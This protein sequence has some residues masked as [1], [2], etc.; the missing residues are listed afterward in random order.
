LKSTAESPAGY[1]M[2][3]AVLKTKVCKWDRKL[4][5]M[6]VNYDRGIDIM[7]DTIEVAIQFGFIDNSVQGSFKL[8]DPDTGELICD[9][10]G[11]EIKIRG[12]KNI[13]PYFEENPIMWRKLYDKVY[14]K[15]SQKQ[16]P[17]IISFER[18][19]NIDLNEKFN[20]DIEQE[21]RDE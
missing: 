15:L 3:A 8:I 1:I 2:E 17:S 21:N 18:M 16:D 10:D 5:R 19:L 14:D 20:I 11:K 7:Q 4:G 12:K 9:E 13:K 6:Y